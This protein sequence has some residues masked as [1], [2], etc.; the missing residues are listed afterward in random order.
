[1]MNTGSELVEIE[2]VEILMDGTSMTLVP[3]ERSSLPPVPMA[4]ARWNE[5]E[6]LL[7]HA[8]DDHD[9]GL[10]SDLVAQQHLLMDET[11]LA[12]VAHRVHVTVSEKV[13]ATSDSICGEVIVA[14]S[15]GHL[16]Y[17]FEIP[18]M[19]PLPT[20]AAPSLMERWDPAVGDTT[21]EVVAA[22]PRRGLLS[23]GTW[24]AGDQ[25]LHANL[26]L[27]AAVLHG[28]DATAADY[29]DVA[30]AMGLDWIILTDHS[31][32]HAWWFGTD[33]YTQAQFES[34]K[35][36]ATQYRQS[37]DWH[38]FYSL[39]M[40]L[41]QTG[42]W[43][44]ASHMLAYPLLNEDAPF[45]ENPS[46]GLV[47]GHAEC[48]S[49]QTIINRINANGYLG[50]IAHPF[51][52]GSL[53]YAKW[54]WDNGATGWAGF[55]LWSSDVGIFADIDA[56]SVG[57]WHSLL[58][59]ISPP[60]GGE[61]A[62]RPNFPTPF[63]VGIGNSDAHEP[64]LIG[65]T[66]TYALLNDGL[67]YEGIAN[68]FLEGT[69]VASNGPLLT[70]A[71][72]TATIGGVAILPNG[73]AVLEV[74]LYSTEEFGSAD[75][76]DVT[77]I[78]NGETRHIIPGNSDCPAGEMD[79]CNGRCCP[80][81]WVAD[82]YCDDGTYEWNGVAIYLNCDTFN[83]DA[84]D[85]DASA[86]GGADCVSG[87]IRDCSGNC[88]P[89]SWVADGYCDDGTYE[90]NGVAIYLNCDTFNCDA[91]DCDPSQCG[92]DGPPSE[93]RHIQIS[94][95]PV[96]S[97]DT[98]VTIEAADGAE[99]KAFTNPIFLQFAI[100]GDS[101]GDGRVDVLDVLALISVWGECTGCPE[102]SNGDGFANTADLLELLDNWG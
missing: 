36:M 34:G 53:T 1:M 16:R 45:L 99:H 54:N 69:F 15:V 33:Y 51:S 24:F 8:G 83:C 4:V 67:T 37:Q 6:R 84:G 56:Q 101:N 91:G 79:D 87:E 95:F 26:S 78:V 2:L 41:G 49:E 88:C 98:W 32:I 62:D 80:T 52:E 48:E 59:E 27:D 100:G 89:A 38:L 61:L 97:G 71:V 40:G 96:G 68:G 64:G 47:F 13:Y 19:A 60:S 11:A 57:K 23:T 77:V 29:A 72:N 82:G 5:L 75:D 55:E 39:E 20:G 18:C 44:L 12:M 28:T 10:M 42:F 50:F 102:D 31:N 93:S 94:P 81:D 90:W 3:N 46:S 58:N 35:A 86:C 7:A 70:A 73:H 9:R 25:H 85:C 17:A 66:F 30:R 21:G 65:A 76:F 22:M 92:G 43:D 14:T 63:P 74:S